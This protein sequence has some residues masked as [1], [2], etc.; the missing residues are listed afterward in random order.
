[1]ALTVENSNQML[2]FDVEPEPQSEHYLNNY[3]CNC[4]YALYVTHIPNSYTEAINSKDT[5]MWKDAM[6]KYDVTC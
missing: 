1:M 3:I 6:I 2:I 5:Q 4:N